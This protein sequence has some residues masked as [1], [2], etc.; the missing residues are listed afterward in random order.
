MVGRAVCLGRMAARP[1]F[2]VS[3]SMSHL[4]TFHGPG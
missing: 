2:M 4:A 3:F 1:V